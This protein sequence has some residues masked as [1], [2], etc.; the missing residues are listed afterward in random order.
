MCRSHVQIRG[1][2]SVEIVDAAVPFRLADNGDD[3]AWIEIRATSS[4]VP[5][6]PRTGTSAGPGASRVTQRLNHH[7]G[8]TLT[9]VQTR[10]P[11]APVSGSAKWQATSWFGAIDRSGGGTVAQR[12]TA[13]GQRPKNAHPG[14]SRN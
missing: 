10:G 1:A 2:G 8:N 14:G 7:G 11:V 6:G 9:G 3:T 4:G 13:L 12:S 5:E